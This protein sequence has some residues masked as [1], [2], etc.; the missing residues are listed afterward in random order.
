MS[1]D[2]TWPSPGRNLTY[3]A[4]R[5]DSL[6]DGRAAAAVA[7]Y[8]GYLSLPT[9]RYAA[10]L[11]AYDS[12]GGNATA[13]RQFVIAA[14]STS[15]GGGALPEAGALAAIS[16][17]PPAVVAA[18]GSGVTRVAL[19]A[20]G[21]APA[22]GART[23]SVIWAVV[24]LPGRAAVGNA[25]GT[26]A[27]VW[28]PPGQYQVGGLH[29]RWRAMG[30][31]FAVAGLT[32]W[33]QPPAF[34]VP[35]RRQH[36]PLAFRTQHCCPLAP[37][38]PHQVG[39]LISDTLGNTVTVR[40]T[41][42]VGAAAAA[43]PAG[44]SSSVNTPPVV[45]AGLKFTAAPGGSISLAGAAADP[46]GDAVALAWT[47]M[48]EASGASSSGSGST[49]RVLA[50]SVPGAYRLLIRASDGRGGVSEAVAAVT[51]GAAAAVSPPPPPPA[52]AV[53]TV[54]PGIYGP[55]LAA[56][57]QL[58]GGASVGRAFYQGAVLDVDA[59]A[60]GVFNLSS[61]E[62][63]VALAGAACTWTLA[64][65]GA[66][67]AGGAT[68]YGCGAPAR[69]RLG[70]PG[71]F[72]LT[73]KAV[74]RATGRVLGG[75]STALTVSAKP[76][77]GDFYSPASPEAFAAGGCAAGGGPP[78]FRGAEFAVL[79]LACGGVGLPDGWGAE[80]GLDGARQALAFGWRLTPLTARAAA[81]H[82]APLVRASAGGGGAAFG[83]A[84]AGLYQVELVGC[85][86]G[87]GTG[88]GGGQAAT[89]ACASAASSRAAYALWGLMVV[90]PSSALAL[91]APR[92]ACAGAA[93]A[94]APA[95]PALLA[96]QTAGAAAW[97]VAWADAAAA[98]GA[99]VVLT[100]RGAGFSFAP[101][102]GRHA[103]T[104]TIDVTEPGMATRRLVGRAT[105][106]ALPCIT[107]TTAAVALNT[108]S[109]ACAAPAAAAPRLLA[110]VPP[111]LAGGAAALA[112]AP[113][114]SLVPG[115]PRAVGLVARTLASNLTATCTAPRVS[116][117]D[118]AP[119]AA[120]LRSGGGGICVA[121]ASGKWACWDA[122]ALVAVS[123]ACGPVTLT[124]A[125]GA[126]T[127]AT[128]CRVL[129]RP[130]GPS[131]CL[132][133]APPPAGSAASAA[134]T[135]DFRVT[136]AAG[137]ALPEPLRLKVTVYK[138]A[139]QGCYAA[140]LAAPA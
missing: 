42:S 19:D 57:P 46:D 105:V 140:G 31:G 96:G 44:T 7:G 106:D 63:P 15:S 58:L 79:S 90:E 136:D 53:L 130:G 71:S 47:L 80:L 25:S 118:A 17:P 120:S 49:V 40:K 126:G 23:L 98:T 70:T 21:S 121:P 20:S 100:G 111:W 38:R 55:R 26:P 2:G 93:V 135:L 1:A 103:A 95:P 5:V 51:V 39:L 78:Q 33:L 66:A 107:C 128:A 10:T 97:S 76:F 109:T 113:G 124:P 115:G 85:A 35:A 34:A 127:R 139:R 8:A 132:Q 67:A 74:D 61:A 4:W 27:E 110:A 68:V 129:T 52:A 82:R 64:G 123:D 77:W 92:P 75:A 43:S 54:A 134:A 60:S 29:A 22:P 73:L 133:A 83:A 59:A 56:A 45:K 62:W 91:P 116:V 112:F 28:L 138:A 94:L 37:P 65:K 137:N 24:S 101:Q 32:T 122:A 125:C 50:G 81:T 102:P 6:P 16:L 117:R 48:A 41:F 72:T 14:S 9:G 86:G 88:S 13:T 36:A 84:A 89:A 131:V 104:V 114:A 12:G 30:L 3:F 18:A 69:F 99:A 108:S 87:G 11:T 119:P